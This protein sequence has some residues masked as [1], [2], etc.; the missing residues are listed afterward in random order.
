MPPDQLM[1]SQTQL[2][3][4]GYASMGEWA[5]NR[6][7]L[8]IQRE[9]LGRQGTDKS[10]PVTIVAHAEALKFV[11]TCVKKYFS[12]GRIVVKTER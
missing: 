10:L 9:L 11:T 3:Q 1:Q 6:S 7:D 5:G 2:F 12:G 4:H 8:Y